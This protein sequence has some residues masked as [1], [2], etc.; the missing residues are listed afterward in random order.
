M[1]RFW[2]WL[3]SR[4]AWRFSLARLVVAVAFMGALI[5][6]NMRRIGPVWLGGTHD[7]ANIY[8]WPLP[9]LQAEA[10]DR[11]QFLNDIERAKWYDAKRSGS[12]DLLPRTHQTYRL[13][14]WN[15]AGGWA[16]YYESKYALF[17]TFNALFALVVLALILFL[18]IPRRKPEPEG[19]R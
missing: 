5:G 9:F 14:D 8:G 16:I 11:V 13:L 10:V 4:F 2:R 19:A 3:R 17:A 6:L 1:K 7:P 18:Q 12:S 15:F